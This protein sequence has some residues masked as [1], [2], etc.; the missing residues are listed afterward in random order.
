MPKRRAK[1]GAAAAAAPVAAPG[2]G[3]PTG[4]GLRTVVDDSLSE[5]SGEER[6]SIVAGAGAATVGYH[7]A[8]KFM[9][10]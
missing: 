3:G 9:T 4:L 5:A 6:S 1:K 7:E 8:Q 10:S 2:R